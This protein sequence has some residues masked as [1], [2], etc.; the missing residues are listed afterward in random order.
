VTVTGGAGLTVDLSLAA[1]LTSVDASGTSGNNTIT[2]DASKAAYTG[3]SG[4]DFVTVASGTVDK[5]ISLG[6]GDDKVTFNAAMAVPTADITGGDGID[7]IAMG[8]G[9]AIAL[10]AGTAFETKIDGFERLGLGQA[11]ANGT[12][13][14]ANMDDIS[15]VFTKGAAAGITL[16]L[17]KMANGGTV[18]Y[19]DNAGGA[20]TIKVV[21]TDATGTADSLNVAIRN[22]GA[23]NVGTLDVAGVESL[24]VNAVDSKTD[25]IDT[26][27][28]SV[29]DAA[30]KSIV[31]TG[32]A[33]LNLT[34]NSAVLTS[35]DASAMTGALQAVTNGTVNETILGGSGDDVLV[36]AG[37]T[38]DVLNGGAGNDIL[39][40]NAGL[41]TL[42][43]GA[44]KD[45]FRIQVAS[46]NSSSYA[47]ITDFAA[48]D[49]IVMAGA[50]SF[51]AAKVVQ[52][53]TAVFQD[54]ANA[55][56]NSIGINDVAWFQYG[57]N[58]YIVMDAG[59]DSTTFT[60]GE[61]FVVRL[62]G[63]VDLTG[64]TFN[65]TSDTIAL[66]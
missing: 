14:L 32:N 49:V 36:A 44:G 45:Q 60:N 6:A 27:V 24:T 42:T 65:D 57:G 9:N 35:L 40:A 38:A 47:T 61:D 20:G 37:K 28:L 5:A 30:A 39:V 2:I 55:A 7:T 26:H 12:I 31:V 4:K 13:N 15:Y 23:L 43:G 34:T 58:T 56:M 41:D 18:D 46:L 51:A 59:L 3:G 66:G 1:S 54:Y 53:D 16:T 10:S 22:D 62:T 25:V 50:D 48:G 8:T 21:M 29:L 63:L 19:N 17:D 11:A 52:A 33:N 64:A